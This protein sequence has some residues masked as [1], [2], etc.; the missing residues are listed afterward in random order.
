VSKN[1]IE[2]VRNSGR[3]E[4]F[5]GLQDVSSGEGEQKFKYGCTEEMEDV[6]SGIQPNSIG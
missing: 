5:L 1:E 6:L 4:N 3:P 2:F